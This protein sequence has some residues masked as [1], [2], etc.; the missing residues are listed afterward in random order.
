MLQ[1]AAVAKK[2]A[3]C[4]SSLGGNG[5]QQP[6]EVQQQRMLAAIAG[7]AAEEDTGSCCGPG[8]HGS[9]HQQLLWL[10]ALRHQITAATVDL[11]V[12]VDACYQA[13]C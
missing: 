6:L 4:C 7:L 11:R 3:S 5:C 1:S 12:V 13:Q 8:R 9:G 10:Q 2:D